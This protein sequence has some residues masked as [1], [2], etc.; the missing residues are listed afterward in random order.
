M[1]L[2]LDALGGDNAPA[3]AIEGAVSFARA[4]P[5]DQLVLVGPE[6]RLRELLGRS[7]ARL[8]NLSFQQASEA[9]AMDDAPSVIRSRRDSSLRV[10]FELA[11]AGSVDAVVSAGNSGAVM[12]GALIIL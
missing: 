2:A 3:A 10:C 11:K 8:S 9:V 4:H 7:A 12:A 6:A 1:R 5:G